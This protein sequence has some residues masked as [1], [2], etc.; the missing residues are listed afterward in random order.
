ME[1]VYALIMYLGNLRST[2]DNEDGQSVDA[3]K[4]KI[5]F[6]LSDELLGQMFKQKYSDIRFK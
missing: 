6:N 5:K 3:D 1:K 2:P 4:I